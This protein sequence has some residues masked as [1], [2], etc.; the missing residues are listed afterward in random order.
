MRPGRR[1]DHED[2]MAKIKNIATNNV[3]PSENDSLYRIINA[4]NPTKSITHIKSGD[5]IPTFPSSC[6]IFPYS[7]MVRVEPRNYYAI[8]GYPSGSHRLLL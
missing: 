7:E 2:L 8:S 4:T 6:L 1:T 3:L 5:I